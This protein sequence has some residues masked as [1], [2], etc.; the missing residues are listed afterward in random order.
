[1]YEWTVEHTKYILRRSVEYSAHKGLPDFVGEGV[2][3]FTT[4]GEDHVEEIWPA[5]SFCGFSIYAL[6]D[7]PFI[8]R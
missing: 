7:A 1:M 8:E 4:H 3:R 5:T 2:L 6:Y